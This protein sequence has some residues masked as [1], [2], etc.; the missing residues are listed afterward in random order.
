MFKEALEMVRERIGSDNIR[1]SFDE[2]TDTSLNSLA[3]LVVSSMNNQ[4]G[5]YLINFEKLEGA[6]NEHIMNFFEESLEV[7]FYKGMIL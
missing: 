7:L 2:T 6:T 5:P 1:V 3:A 4:N